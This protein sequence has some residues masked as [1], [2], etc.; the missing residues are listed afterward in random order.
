MASAGRVAL[1]NPNRGEPTASQDFNKATI[2]SD[3]TVGHPC[4]SHIAVSFDLASAEPL[5]SRRPRCPRGK[6]ARSARRASDGP[7]IATSVML[8][9]TGPQE[10]PHV[11]EPHAG[12]A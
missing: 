12:A 7:L 8:A 2:R 10:A 11:E 3:E 1:S 6:L 4:N 5:P 9:P